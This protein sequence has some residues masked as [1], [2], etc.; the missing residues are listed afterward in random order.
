MYRSTQTG[1]GKVTGTGIDCPGDCTESVSTSEASIQLTAT[2]TEG[3]RFVNWTGDINLA[4]NPVTV[5]METNKNVTANFAINTY[6]IT[7]TAGLGGTITPS[8][9]VTVNYGGSQTYFITPN[10]G[11][12][13]MGVMVD[14]VSMGAVLT[15]TFSNVTSDHTIEVIFAINQYSITATAGANGTISPLG[16]LILNYGGSQTFTITPNS[17]YHV[18]E[19]KVDGVSV[20]AVTTFTFNNVTSNHTIEATFEVDNSPPVADAGPDQNVITGQSG[21]PKRK[22]KL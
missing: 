12:H 22:Q 15:H 10:L 18:A 6:A 8:G 20:G 16:T 5:N 4:D 17:G 2:P 13:L 14:G 3:Y 7:A 19:V 9:S 1:S 11:Y 21:Y